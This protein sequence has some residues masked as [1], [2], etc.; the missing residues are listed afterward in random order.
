MRI[1]RIG[2]IPCTRP[3]LLRGAVE[4]LTDCE[5][6]ICIV[7]AA[8]LGEPATRNRLIGAVRDPDA[9]IRFMDDDDFAFPVRYVLGDEMDV[10]AFGYKVRESIVHPPTSPV[11]AAVNSVING[12]WIV[13][14]SALERVR[15]KFGS[16]YDPAWTMN[17]GT[18]F[19]LR[20][21]D[22]GL[23]IRI[24]PEVIG[25]QWFPSGRTKDDPELYEDLIRRGG[26]G[27]GRRIEW[28]H[29]YTQ[30]A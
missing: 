12:N 19:W 26:Q 10:L 1:G 21:L 5:Q 3:D 18:R 30:E 23:K 27:V 13:R 25:Y 17:T 4:T 15:E 20:M 22:A 28:D 2:L 24:F 16:Y 9:E 6:V 7:D 8:R 11:Q 14:R 29:R